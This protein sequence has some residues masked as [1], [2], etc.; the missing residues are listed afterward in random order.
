MRLFE[1]LR[2]THRNI[3]IGNRLVIA[4]MRSLFTTGQL[5]P[6]GMQLTFTPNDKACFTIRNVRLVT[7]RE[8][9]MVS[10]VHCPQKTCLAFQRSY[11]ST[12]INSSCNTFCDFIMKVAGPKRVHLLPRAGPPHAGP[13]PQPH[14]RR[15]EPCLAAWTR[16]TV[17]AAAQ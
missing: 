9:R 7:T 2:P 5:C 12:S 1:N 14:R 10:T 6:G 3:S 13:G 8:T 17:P 15:G 16:V 11:L 4:I